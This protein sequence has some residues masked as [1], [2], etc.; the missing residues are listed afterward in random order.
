MGVRGRPGLMLADANWQGKRGERVK[1]AVAASLN[2]LLNCRGEPRIS[3][4]VRPR[5]A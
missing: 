3:F 5:K 4:E 1:L 2:Y